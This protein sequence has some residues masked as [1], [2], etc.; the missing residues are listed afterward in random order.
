M[1][2]EDVMTADPYT[3]SPKDTVGRALE[4]LRELDIRHILVTD[5]DRLVGMLSDRDLRSFAL[6][7][8]ATFEHPEEA[9]ER[10][11]AAL[12]SVMSADAM[13]VGP[14]DEISEVVDVMLDHKVGAVPV[15]DAGSD[16]L[17]GII[18]YIDVLR[19]SRDLW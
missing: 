1:T 5:D 10:T 7:P 17:L 2:A 14:G 16:T 11:G 3:M 12:G 4:M 9:R 13:T 8:L 18:S 15:V 19:A 6:P